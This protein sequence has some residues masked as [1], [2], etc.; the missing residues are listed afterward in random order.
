MHITAVVLN[1]NTLI[2]IIAFHLNVGGKNNNNT[3]ENTIII[4]SRF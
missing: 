1:D 4:L 2:N 3:N